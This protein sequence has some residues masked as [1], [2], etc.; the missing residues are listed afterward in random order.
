MECDIANTC[1]I[2]VNF[3]C[4]RVFLSGGYGGDE[5]WLFMI[6]THMNNW[7]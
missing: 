4:V 7:Y 5:E 3:L 1:Y 6:L 2:K